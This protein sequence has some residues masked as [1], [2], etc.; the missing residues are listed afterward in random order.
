MAELIARKSKVKFFRFFDSG[1]LQ[2]VKMLDDIVQIAKLLPGIK[3]WLPT[4][5][6]EIVKDFLAQG[7]KFPRNLTV[8]ISAVMVGQ[9]TG[10]LPKGTQGSTVSAGVGYS[11]PAPTQENNCGD[12]RACWQK[13]VESV[14]YHLH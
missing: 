1:D 8:R 9:A 6:R 2:S 14:D 7:K 13:S 11:C 12:C 10:P 5:E 3:F 4:R